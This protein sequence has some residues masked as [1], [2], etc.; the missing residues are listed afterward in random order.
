L[1]LPVSMSSRFAARRV[2]FLAMERTEHDVCQVQ[3][4][5]GCG[6]PTREHGKRN[7]PQR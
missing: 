7:N 5:A 3:G 6:A 4:L 2:V 1:S